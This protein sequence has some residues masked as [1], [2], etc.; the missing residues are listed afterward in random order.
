MIIDDSHRIDGTDWTSQ[1]ASPLCRVTL[2]NHLILLAHISTQIDHNRN[3]ATK[4]VLRDD[5]V[6]HLWNLFG[7]EAAET[8]SIELLRACC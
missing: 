3:R 1:R 7:N 6:D 2:A 5:L 8:I 4:E